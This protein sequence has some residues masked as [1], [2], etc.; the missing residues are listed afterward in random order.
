MSPGVRFAEVTTPPPGA[1][2]GLPPKCAACSLRQHVDLLSSCFE[3]LAAEQA[4]G[5]LRVRPI[6]LESG[7]E[8]TVPGVRER[9][10]ADGSVLAALDSNALEPVIEQLRAA[11]DEIGI[12]FLEMREPRPGGTRGLPDHPPVH[13]G[14]RKVFKG[15]LILNSDYTK[16]SAQAAIDSGVADGIAFGRPFIAN[17]DLVERLRIDASR[18]AYF[19]HWIT[20]PTMNKRFDTRFF[21]ATLPPGQE[22]RHDGRETSS[23]EWLRPA[24]A[25]AR[26]RRGEAQLVPP[27]FVLLSELARHPDAAS[28]HSAAA[29]RVGFH[30][31]AA[32]A[33]SARTRSS[34][35]REVLAWATRITSSN[36][37]RTARWRATSRTISGGRPFN[38][39][40]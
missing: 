26:Y 23:G 28:A 18:L 4:A 14:M 6:V 21:L 12:A 1:P 10:A 38:R 9:I 35:S 15:P 39:S 31:R 17:P 13:P 37:M 5:R 19:D 7:G 2:N 24:E 27:T 11:L 40:R 8:S 16:A 34:R 33:Y 29:K 30:A 25:L 32:R 3:L 22:A 20:P 36:D